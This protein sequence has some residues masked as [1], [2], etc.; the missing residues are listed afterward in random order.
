MNKF[1]FLTRSNKLL[2]LLLL[3]LCSGAMACNG[4][5]HGDA[6]HTRLDETEFFSLS[7]DGVSWDADNWNTY[8]ILNDD[9]KH[10]TVTM[11]ADRSAMDMDVENKGWLIRFY[12]QVPKER[13]TSLKGSYAIDPGGQTGNAY[14]QH[15]EMETLSG[16]GILN[17]DQSRVVHEGNGVTFGIL[18]GTFELK[19]DKGRVLKGKFSIN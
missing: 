2:F 10:Y 15:G 8:A 11:E 3:L 5:Q 1:S 17:I 12:L 4:Q 16:K 14:F 9:Q 19:T 18:T 7:I 13:L 6:L